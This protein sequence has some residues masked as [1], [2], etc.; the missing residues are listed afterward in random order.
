METIYVPIGMR[1]G[2]TYFLRGKGLRLKAYPFD[3]N[4]A[5]LK[6]IYDILSNLTII[7]MKVIFNRMF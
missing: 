6:I 1:C 3:W 7:F 4:C 2:P 5:S